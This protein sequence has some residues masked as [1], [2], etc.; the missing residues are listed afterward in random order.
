[1]NKNSDTSHLTSTSTEASVVNAKQVGS[2]D[3][4]AI[5]DLT[6]QDKATLTSVKTVKMAAIDLDSSSFVLGY[7]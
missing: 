1:M 2:S 7:N 6:K 3:D 4:L 5:A